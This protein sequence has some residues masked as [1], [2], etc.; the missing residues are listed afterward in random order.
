[1]PCSMSTLANVAHGTGSNLIHR[2]SEVMLKERRR[3]VV[4]PR[5]TPLSTIHLENMLTL[6]RAGAVV[7]PAMPGLYNRPATVEDMI[8]FVVARA[9]DHLGVE[10]ALAPRWGEGRGVPAGR[11][12][13]TAAARPPTRASP[14]DGSRRRACGGC[15]TA[16]PRAT[17]S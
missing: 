16:S 11:A 1:M 13:R 17:T 3:L 7:L 6:T 2:T 14:P 4:V 10:T 8:D 15:S 5:E 9:L 12:P